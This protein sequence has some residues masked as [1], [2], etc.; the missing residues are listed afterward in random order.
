MTADPEASHQ[1]SATRLLNLIIALLVHPR[2]RTRRQLMDQLEIADPR[3]F[4]RLKEDLRGSLGVALEEVD[5]LYRLSAAGYAM[6]PLDFTAEERAAISLALG[7]WRGSEVEAAAGAA[8]AKLTPLGLGGQAGPSGLDTALHAPTPGALEIIAAIAE[9]R[10]IEFKYV[11]GYSGELTSRRV[12]P[13]RLTKF[14]GACYLLGFDQGRGGRRIFNLSRIAGPVAA[15]SPAGAFEPPPPA[16]AGRWLKA[17]LEGEARPAALVKAT[18]EAARVLR[19]AGAAPL[20]DAVWQVPAADP[21]ALAAWGAALEVLDPPEL[22]Q[23]VRLRLQG[24]AE[25]HQGEARQPLAYPGARPRGRRR[26]EGGAERAARMVSLVSCLR[27]GEPV[28]LAQLADRFG[29]SEAAVKA[30][31]YTLWLD[32]GRSKAGGDLLDFWW[33]DDESEVALVDSQGLDRPVRLSAVEAITLIAALRSL[34]EARGLSEAS[35]AQSARAKLEAALGPADLL[36][37]ELPAAPP[38]LA[39]LRQGLAAGRRLAF[40][41]VNQSGAESRRR[42]DPLGLF[43][44]QDHWL[45]A[46]WDL[47]AEA[48][49]YFRVDRM[50]E[51]QLLDEPATAHPYR[52]GTS[53]WSGRGELRVDVV[54]AARE[55][56]R[57]EELET[58]APPLALPGGSVQVK[59]AVGNPE[60]VTRLA[61][62]AGGAIEVLAPGE[63][64][65]RVLAAARA[66]LAAS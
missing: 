41:Y 34:E 22:R 45:L 16:A 21:F 58:L 19:A 18:P 30:D 10:A 66:A 62:G 17:A 33:S 1:T 3:M 36:D 43:S 44:A 46:A 55:R 14:R 24:A 2:G 39:A 31:L 61:L 38:A 47:E 35:A 29:L 13:W 20:P 37:L 5:G 60:W 12:E 42:V 6:P 65:Q 23:A 64:R 8:R 25:A 27:H 63:V 15:R 56:W 4:E 48:E 59:L 50:A 51:V 11:V 57:A 9:R 40:G 54:F 26:G 53:G 49:R 28:P 52:P 7:E 32:V